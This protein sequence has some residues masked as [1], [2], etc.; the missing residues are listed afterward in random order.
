[1]HK[2]LSKTEIKKLNHTFS[3]G[4]SSDLSL[5]FLL[6]DVDDPINLGAI[7]RL[8]D[9]SGADIIITGKS[10]K[11]SD[12]KVAMTSRGLERSV[13]H[14]YYE[15]IEDAVVKLKTA[16][17]EIIGV[18]VDKISVVY[19]QNKYSNKTCL[20]LGNEAD[21]L[22]KKTLALCDNIVAVPMLGKGL[23]LNVQTAAAV[24]AYE[25]LRQNTRF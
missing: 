6:Q 25:V 23:S 21:G 15:K 11:T 8:A 16:G 22:Y 17:Y 2:P 13:Q 24:V 12:P 9:A 20:V 18:E 3:E 19:H 14:S 1:M 7:F 10:A 5:V 4:I